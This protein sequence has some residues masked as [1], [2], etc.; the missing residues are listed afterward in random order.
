MYERYIPEKKAS[1][2]VKGFLHRSYRFSCYPYYGR[3]KWV[4]N[5]SDYAPIL[6][7]IQRAFLPGIRRPCAICSTSYISVY[8]PFPPFYSIGNRSIGSQCKT[9]YKSS[10]NN[11]FCYQLFELKIV[12]AIV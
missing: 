5:G 4:G 11:Y 6:H 7:G 3:R 8:P 12:K 2:D 9:G 10:L 1:F